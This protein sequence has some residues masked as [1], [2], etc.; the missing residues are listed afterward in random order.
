MNKIKKRILLVLSMVLLVTV[1]VVSTYAFL[2]SK[3]SVTNTFSVGKVA[4]TLD[5]T[6]VDEY[7]NAVTP[8]SRVK[9]NSY[10]LIPGHTYTKDPVVHFLKD[11]E[12][13]YLF[14]K[15]VNGIADIEAGTTI[16]AQILA[17]GW[18]ALGTANPGVYYK[19]VSGTTSDVDYAVFQSFQ[20][21]DDAD[22]SGYSS[23]TIIITAYAIQADGFDN[24][25]A[26]F[27]EVSK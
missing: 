6:K 27:N 22:V 23:A 1:S 9:A 7:G 14:V 17:N 26:A 19:L 11:S 24:A 21:A 8:T 15:V 10:K 12:A 3:D 25:I 13:S 20:V 18:T 2:S 5:E 16:D 4:I